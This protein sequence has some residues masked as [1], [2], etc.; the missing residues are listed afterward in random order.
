MSSRVLS[1][2]DPV[3]QVFFPCERG[4]TLLQAFGAA[5]PEDFGFIEPK[6]FMD[7]RNSAFSGIPEWDEFAT[8]VFSCTNCGEV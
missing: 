4:T 8:H 2:Q 3:V 1:R 6:D 7:L 5:R